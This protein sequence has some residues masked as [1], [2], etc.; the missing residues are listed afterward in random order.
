MGI[1]SV[2]TML[3]DVDGNPHHTTVLFV[4]VDNQGVFANGGGVK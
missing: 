3:P 2:G 1:G 4:H